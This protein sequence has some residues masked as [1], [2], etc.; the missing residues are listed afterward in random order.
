MVKF[1][2]DL[3]VQRKGL[4]VFLQHFC[5]LVVTFAVCMTWASSAQLVDEDA[6]MRFSEHVAATVHEQR[7]KLDA[8]ANHPDVVASIGTGNAQLLASLEKQL[9]EGTSAM[10][11]KLLPLGFDDVDRTVD[12]PIGFA[13]LDM[14]KVSRETGERPA[15]EAHLVGSKDA[16]IVVV[17]RISRGDLLVGHA[18]WALDLN[19]VVAA[20]RSATFSFGYAELSQKLAEGE[21]LV[22]LWLGDELHRSGPPVYS[23]DID[24]TLWGMSFWNKLET[25]VFVGESKTLPMIVAGAGG[26]SVLVLGGWLFIRSRKRESRT[27]L[28]TPMMSDSRDDGR[29]TGEIR[30]TKDKSIDSVVDKRDTGPVTEADGHLAEGQM[31]SEAVDYFAEDQIFSGGA[32]ATPVVEI[33]RDIFRAYDIRGIVPDFLNSD[34]VREIGRAI[35]SEAQDRGQS[36]LVVGRDGRLTGPELLGALTDGIRSTGLDVIDIGRVPTPVL[37]FAT[38]YLNTGSGVIV[39]G[40]HNPSSYNGLK[41]ML[42]G[43]TLFGDDIVALRTRIESGKL[44]SGT[45]G[46]QRMDLLPEYI[47]RVTED[48]PAAVGNAYKIVVDCGNGVAGDVAPRLL[49]ALGHDVI[50][51]F[52]EVDGAFP[53]HHPDPSKPE[54]LKDLITAVKDHNADIGFAFDGDGDRLGIVD[55]AGRIVWPDLQM[56][57]YARDIL[58]RNPGVPIVYDVKCTNK[59]GDIINKLG[60]KPLMWKTG[61]SFIKNKMKETGALLAGEMSGHIFFKERWYG[62]DD[63]LYSASRMLEILMELKQ[64]PAEVFAKLPTGYATPEITLNLD[65][66]GINHL[67]VEKVAAVSDQFADA[68]L[69]MIDGVR[70]DFSDGWGL[71]RASNTTPS[72]VFRFEADS[73]D[74]L[75]RIAAQFKTV[76]LSIDPDLELPF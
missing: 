30:E 32:S 64:P 43:D 31:D 36:S 61:H 5:A 74:A 39:T 17:S 65:S 14:L 6:A 59:L 70:V 42:G 51:L 4:G 38:H 75:S 34:V 71:V 41:I 68:K 33:S 62:F 16:H 22:L 10:S 26:V 50:E 21:P 28:K 1:L 55:V 20:A 37:Y 60:G 7:S 72:L 8:A 11:V 63:A 66:E 29:A 54:N 49:R 3:T 46:L 73:Q 47:R 69:T 44:R 58:S 76:L 18:R 25:P 19:I 24:G 52:C 27:E 67:L 35:G 56:M 23:K 48:V 2:S 45:G 15:I 12:P 57:L 9:L 13:V 40:S 53:N